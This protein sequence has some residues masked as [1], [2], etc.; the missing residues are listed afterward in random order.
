MALDEACYRI[1]RKQSVN[2]TLQVKRIAFFDHSDLCNQV[3][4]YNFPAQGEQR[5]SLVA[6]EKTKSITIEKLTVSQLQQYK[7]DIWTL[8]PCVFCLL[9]NNVSV[10]WI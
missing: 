6:T 2:C 4:H 9:H 7:A 10:S 3:F 5:H 1:N 8:S